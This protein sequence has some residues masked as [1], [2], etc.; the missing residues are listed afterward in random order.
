MINNTYKEIMAFTGPR[1]MPTREL[2]AIGK[3]PFS[4]RKARVGKA[5]SP[6]QERGML[7][8]TLL[9]R[10][11]ATMLRENVRVED[12]IPEGFAIANAKGDV[13]MV[14]RDGG[15]LVAFM[16]DKVSPG[17]QVEWSYQIKA[18]S[19]TSTLKNPSTKAFR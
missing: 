19:E 8:V 10:N 4:P 9:Y 18:T 1:T 11:K 7:Q 2:P 17:E 6:C 14:A 13:E 16:L 15:T 5:I 12:F 3:D